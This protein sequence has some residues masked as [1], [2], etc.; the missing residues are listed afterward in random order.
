FNRIL[1][2]ESE[3]YVPQLPNAPKPNVTLSAVGNLLRLKRNYP[4]GFWKNLSS[5]EP[6]DAVKLFVNIYSNPALTWEQVRWLRS[7]TILASTT[8]GMLREVYSE[9]AGEAVE[10]EIIVANHGG[11]QVDRATDTLSALRAIR[12]RLPKPFPILMDSGIRSGSDIFKAIAS[13]ADAVLIGRPYA[14]GL[15]VNGTAGVEAVINNLANDFELTARLSG[16]RNLS[17]IN[18]LRLK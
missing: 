8:Q 12:G 15:A 10:N 1:K 16:C 4:G 9:A 6:L 7:H 11:R 17:E 2:E 14:Y 13:G 18:E 3:K 5:S